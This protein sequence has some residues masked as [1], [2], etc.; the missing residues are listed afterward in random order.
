M[1]SLRWT[2]ASQSFQQGGFEAYRA[3]RFRNLG[4]AMMDL[5]WLGIWM[6]GFGTSSFGIW[7]LAHGLRLAALEFCVYG[8]WGVRLWVWGLA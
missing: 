3:E 8:V 1:F 6:W 5:G 2:L 4:L 7:G